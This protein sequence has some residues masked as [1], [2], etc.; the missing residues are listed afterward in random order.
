MLAVGAALARFKSSGPYYSARSATRNLAP[1]AANHSLG[2]QCAGV[3]P[4]SQSSWAARR[5]V[6]DSSPH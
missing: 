4:G 3:L 1:F 2:Q 5:E 6:G